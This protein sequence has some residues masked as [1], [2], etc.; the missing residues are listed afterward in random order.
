D[1]GD[2]SDNPFCDPTNT[3]YSTAVNGFL[4]M[5]TVDIG[6]H[7]KRHGITAIDLVS[8]TAH[9]EA[10]SM[11]ISWETG[12]EIDNAG[13]VLFRNVAGTTEYK[14]ISGMVEAR[15]TAASGGSY[16]F[17]DDTVR[18]GILYEYWLVDIETSGKW[19]GHGPVTAKLPSALE[20][21]ELLVLNHP[22]SRR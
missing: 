4:D 21:T 18:R 3:K 11:I 8:F 14:Q 17:V 6:Y 9:E 22:V 16:R 20:L 15:G 2:P 5:N 7:Y 13:F 10:S 12:A 19:T 1:A